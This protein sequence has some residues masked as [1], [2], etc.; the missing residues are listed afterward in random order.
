MNESLFS[1]KGKIA[2]I[3]G[4]GGGVGKAISLA[5]AQYG[6]NV[7][8]TE[9]PGEEKKLNESKELIEGMG[10]N[11]FVTTLDVTNLESIKEL[12]VVVEEHFGKIDIL[13]NNAGA[14]LRAP[15]LDVTE[16]EW[17][18]VQDI[19]LKGTFFT[20]QQVAKIMK[21]TGGGKIINITSVHGINGFQER[22]AYCSSKAGVVNLT[23]VLA[24]DWAEHGI[25]VN[26][27]GPNYMRTPLTE[28]ILQDKE[29]YDDVIYRTPLKKIAEPEDLVGAIVYL[30]SPSSNFVTGHTLMVDGGW[31]AW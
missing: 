10:N 25:N 29:F 2:V 14:S 19:N 23:K 30:A 28:S 18:H 16:K 3:T 31:T 9:R 20:S 26:A 21:K 5:L 17:D 1:L 6:A 15:S 4:A 7:V 24:I 13:V 22:A 27:V 12:T 11:V 8:L